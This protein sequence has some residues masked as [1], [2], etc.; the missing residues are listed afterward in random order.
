LA[1]FV[2]SGAKG[3]L[4]GYCSVVCCFRAGSAAEGRTHPA[5]RPMTTGQ[6]QVPLAALVAQ[7]I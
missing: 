4:I 3:I 6:R 2:G 7:A 5:E 1:S